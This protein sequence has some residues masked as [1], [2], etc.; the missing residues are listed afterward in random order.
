MAFLVMEYWGKRTSRANNNLLASF[1][2]NQ[3]AVYLSHAAM[4]TWLSFA[5]VTFHP[6]GI[7]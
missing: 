5:R 7:A 3:L 1:R 4:P 2:F 6:L